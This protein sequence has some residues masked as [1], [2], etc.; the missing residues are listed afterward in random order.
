MKKI[1]ERHPCPFCGTKELKFCMYES[2]Q[3]YYC[4]RCR[5]WGRIENLPDSFKKKLNSRSITSSVSLKEEP[6]EFP[7]GFKLISPKSKGWKYLERR[8]I[9]PYPLKPF[10]GEAKN[11]IVFPFYDKGNLVYYVQRKLYGSGLRYMN[12]KSEGKS[13]LFIPYQ[14]GTENESLI[15]TEGVFDCLNVY[16]KS[17]IPTI[18]LLGKELN[19]AKILTIL[20][21]ANNEIIILLDSSSQDKETPRAAVEMRDALKVFHPVKIVKCKQGKDPA[22]LTKDEIKEILNWKN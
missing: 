8:G 16:Q 7:D 12:S 9:S 4:F 13:F 18:A 17:L 14:M 10:V 3:T 11:Y 2:T 1:K 5:I 15:I 19:H 21:Y 20:E 22:E 6:L